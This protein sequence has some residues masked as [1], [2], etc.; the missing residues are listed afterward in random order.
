V[1]RFLDAKRIGANNLD[2]CA[3]AGMS[4]SALYLWLSK[5][6]AATRGKYFD[7]L[8]EYKKAESQ[9]VV[10]SL[11]TIIKASR[12]GTWQAAAWILERTRPHHY[13]LHAA[14]F[15]KEERERLEATGQEAQEEAAT[16]AST[17]AF[18][19]D[20]ATRMSPEASREL[21]DAIRDAKE[22]SE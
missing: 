21:L 15:A 7:F 12:L 19:L 9:V 10:T 20:I 2:A 1:R 3:H 22:P 6:R 14:R 11:A 8:Q 18:L 13:S 17:E 16:K 5:G 4:K